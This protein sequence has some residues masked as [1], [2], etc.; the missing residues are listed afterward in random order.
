MV[1]AGLSTTSASLI[2]GGVKRW[3]AEV[4][5]NNTYC[6]EVMFN[7]ILCVEEGGGAFIWDLLSSNDGRDPFY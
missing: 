4:T 2:S 5:P 1:S 7:C 6:S 3:E